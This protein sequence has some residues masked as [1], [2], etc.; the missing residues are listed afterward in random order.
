MAGCFAVYGH[1][2]KLCYGVE[3]LGG[4]GD[5]RQEPSDAGRHIPAGKLTGRSVL[6]FALLCAFGF[7]LSC[8]LFLP[9]TLPIYLSVP[10]LLFLAGYSHAKRFTWLAHHWLGTALMLAPICAW[11]AVRGEVVQMTLSDLWPPIALG[12]AVLLW[13][14]GFDIL[15]A[16]QDADFDRR[17]NLKSIPARFGVRGAL[18]IAAACHAL[19]WCVLLALGWL[20]P[21]LSLSWIWFV[22]VLAIGGLLVYEHSIVKPDDLSKVN[23]AFFQVNAFIS[24]L[25][26]AVGSLDAL[27]R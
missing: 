12:L 11:I 18:R 22:S 20:L 8:L 14:S 25:L 16:C 21:E 10:V 4:C 1:R 2:T 13:V 15:Y 26:L 17:E 9:N 6:F 23:I 7:L 5:R 3:S 24:M 27:L 19:M